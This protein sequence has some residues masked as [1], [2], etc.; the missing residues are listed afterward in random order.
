MRPNSTV[1]LAVFLVACAGALAQTPATPP[2][3][4]PAPP[5][6]AQTVPAQPA[7]P[8]QAQ[9]APAAPAQPPDPV[10]EA[11][12]E[13]FRK[14]D[15]QTAVDSSKKVLEGKP[16]DFDAMYIAGVSSLR[17]GQFDPAEGYFNK[18]LQLEPRYPN[19]F[20]HLGHLAF[21]R[22]E[23]LSKEGRTEEA[24]AQYVEA[25]KKFAV[26][27]EREPGQDK[28]LRAR[29][30][31]LARAGDVD[32]AIQAYEATIAAAPETLSPYLALGSVYAELG[33]GDDAIK[34]LA[35]APKTNAKAAADGAF[36]I[37]RT[38]YSKEKYAET[39]AFIQK[40]QEMS[41]D[42]R[43]LHGLLSATY[44][45]LG[46]IQESAQ[47]LCKFMSL[48]PPQEESENV[49]EVLKMAFG[50]DWAEEKAP[51][52]LPK[53]ALPELDRKYSPKYPPEARK[54]RIETQVMLMVQVKTDG[55]VGDTCTVPSGVLE[56]LRIYG[57]EQAAIECVKRWKFLPAKSAGEPVEAYYPA[58]VAFS[59]R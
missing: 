46:K 40:M 24:K 47:E 26:E 15:Y 28:T 31:A 43:P 42:S 45:R 16:E 21:A 1:L 2:D 29:A 11:A 48:K 17:L 59:M 33:R 22:A 19:V 50:G 36:A 53:G 4:P 30:L 56:Q 7:Q 25:S 41:L 3:Q 12:K 37:A 54:D 10:L 18:L 44:A 32:G 49:G 14:G 51:K 6:P 58:V 38:L 5:Q 34:M 13:A 55:T 27:L 35:R 57:V 20:F 23:E 9:A 52:L 8:A 39:L